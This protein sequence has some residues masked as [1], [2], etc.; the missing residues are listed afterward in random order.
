MLRPLPDARTYISASPDLLPPERR[1]N[2]NGVAS[3]LQIPEALR[4]RIEE[5][6]AQFKD[7]FLHFA[8][9]PIDQPV[10][11]EGFDQAAWLERGHDRAAQLGEVYPDHLVCCCAEKVVVC[12]MVAEQLDYACLLSGQYARDHGWRMPG[13]G[14]DPD[15]PAGIRIA[16]EYGLEWGLWAGRLRYYQPP[17][18]LHW[19][20]FPT[21]RSLG[22]SSELEER[23]R[24]WNEI[25]QR[26]YLGV[27]TDRNDA[28]SDLGLTGIGFDLPYW[29]DDVDPV[30]WYREGLGIA[31]RLAEELPG[32]PVRLDVADYVHARRFL[33]ITGAFDDEFFS[34]IGQ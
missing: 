22:L 13:D 6:I 15:Q 21:P 9:R 20:G 23:L 14:T 16:P 25:W 17:R 32:V 30:A 12:E 7:N 5:W 18:L 28:V 29:S 3:D 2:I 10:W 19:M 11:R 4:E 31:A 27:D 1:G 24:R 8:D 33:E 34:P 26:G